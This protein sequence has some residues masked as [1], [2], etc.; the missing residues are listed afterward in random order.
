M[1]AHALL[2]DDVWLPFCQVEAD[3]L[4]SAVVARDVAAAAAHA[5][6]SVNLWQHHRVSVELRGLD[7]RR[8]LL[9][10]KV[11]KMLDATLSHVCRHAH[12]QVVDDAVA[13][14]HDSRA[15]LYVAAAYLDILQSVPP[16]LNA[17]DA[18]QLDA[19]HDL[20]LCHF[21][22]ETLSNGLHSTTRVARHRLLLADLSLW[23]EGD[24]LDGVD[25]RNGVCS[26][27]VSTQ[28]RLSHMCDVRRHLRNDGNLHVL[29]DVGSIGCDEFVVLSHIAAHASQSHLRAGEVQFHCVAASKLSHLGKL[30]PLLFELT[31]D[32]GNHHFRRIVLLQTL[33]NVE[34]HLVRVLAQ[35]FHVAEASKGSVLLD[36]VE[37]GRDLSDVLFANGLVEDTCPAHVEG[38]SYHV[39]VRAD[40]RRGQEEG[41]LAFDTAESDLQRWVCVCHF[42]VLTS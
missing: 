32:A 33:Q 39:V 14:L 22:D 6:L 29:L 8:Q 37:S 19:L 42:A 16:R 24:A 25:G 18:A 23:R 26:G 28:S 15:D 34:V 31:H 3:G 36:C 9:A 2:A 5:F 30:Y 41:V 40:G 27:K 11:L 10:D 4:V 7:E 35:L 17:T 13:I 21:E 20:V 1:A 12:K 38:A